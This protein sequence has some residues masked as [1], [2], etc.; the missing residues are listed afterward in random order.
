MILCQDKSLYTGISTNPERRFQ[1]HAEM[2]S[3]GQGRGAKYFRGRPPV[4]TVLIIENLD[5]SE[6]SKEEAQIKKLS[7]RQKLELIGMR[8]ADLS[9]CL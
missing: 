5:K 1:E 7:R 9:N 6:A 8:E 4:E 2:A 3:T